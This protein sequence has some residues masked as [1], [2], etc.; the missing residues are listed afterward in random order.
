MCLLKSNYSTTQY[1]SKARER[2]RQIKEEEIKAKLF[3]ERVS[4]RNF[5]D[6]LLWLFTRRNDGD[7]IP[8]LGPPLGVF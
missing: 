4:V 5:T 3:D 1:G 2:D 8:I 7:N 6:G